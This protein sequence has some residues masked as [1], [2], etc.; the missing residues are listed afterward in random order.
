MLAVSRMV[1]PGRSAPSLQFEDRH[2][3]SG[4]RRNKDDTVAPE[5]GFDFRTCLS[6][7]AT[8]GQGRKVLVPIHLYC[9]GVWPI[10]L[11]AH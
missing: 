11:S 3:V 6:C 1:W 5:V 10:D 9:G 4:P 2:G 8:A 7:A